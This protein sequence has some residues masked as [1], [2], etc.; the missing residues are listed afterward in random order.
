MLQNRMLSV[1]LPMGKAMFVISLATGLFLGQAH[2]VASSLV[3]SPLAPYP[4]NVG[5]GVGGPMVMLAASRDESLFSPIYTDYEDIDGGGIDFTFK[6]TF[7]YYGYFDPLKCYTY[8]STYTSSELGNNNISG[9]FEPAVDVANTTTHACPT[10][11]RYWSGNFLNWATMTRIDVVR[12]MLYGGFRRVDT[13]TDTTLEMA[14]MSQDAHSFVKYYSG[15]DVRNYTPF[16]TSELVVPGRPGYAG[17]TICNRSS[18]NSDPTASEPGAPLMRIAPGNY[19]LWATIPGSV[20]RWSGELSGFAFGQKTNAFY[21]KYGPAQGSSSSD[22]TA[23]QPGLP[24][25]NALVGV[26]P[27]LA[28]RVQVC[29]AGLLGSE[30]CQSYGAAANP[31][32]KPVGLLQEFGTT[33]NLNDPARAEF[34]L[35][36]GSYDANLRGGAL[37]KNVASLND[38]VDPA[39]GR[40]C[41][42]MPANGRPANCASSAGVIASFD[43][44]RLFDQGQYN[45]TAPV[46]SSGAPIGFPHPTQIRNGNFASWGNPVSEMVVQAISYFA[47]RDISNP[48]ETTRDVKVGLPTGVAVQ[49]PLDNTRIDPVAQVSRSQLYGQG[50]CRAANLLAI[51][52]GTTSFDTDEGTN[53]SEHVYGLF[54][55]FA[56]LN[57]RPN[58][59]LVFKTDRIGGLEGLNGTRRSVG[60]V[61][62]GFGADCSAKVIGAGG[63]VGGVYSR[64]LS[65]VTGVCPEAPA[66][67]GT[68]LGA[69]AAF[70][71]N[72][73]AIRELGG[74]GRSTEL[75][76]ATGGSIPESRLPPHAL[77]VRTYAASLAGGVAR[78]D[79]PIPGTNNKVYITPE[80]AWDHGNSA[81]L[82]TGAM[83]TF[84]AIYATPA[85][86][87]TN[88]SGA[89]VV[90]WNDTQF[91][92]D[93]DMDLV[94]FI[95]WELRPVAGGAFDLEVMTDVLNHNA[96]A[97][98]SHGFSVIG[99]DTAPNS[100]YRSDGRFITHGSNS[101]QGAGSRCAELA[102]NT[103][104]YLTRC[105][106]SDGGMRTSA[107][108]ASSRDGFNWPTSFNGQGVG[109]L[110]D[111]TRPL[112]TTVLTRFRVSNGVSAVTL[113]DPLWYLAKYGSFDTGETEFAA[114]SNAVPSPSNGSNPVNWDSENND[115]AACSSGAG[116]ADGEPDGY[117]LAR[118]PELLEARLRVL[119][120]RIVQSSNALPAVS[121]AQLIND[122]FKY[123]AE[124][125]AQ[126]F[127][128]TIKAFK[129]E[130]GEFNA[131]ESWDAGEA[132]TLASENNTR[133]I[134]TNQVNAAGVA[135]GMAFTVG[136]INA[137]AVGP[138][139]TTP[140]YK[141]TLG[142]GDTA[143]LRTRADRLV[144]YIRGSRADERTLFRPR[145]ATNLMG[146]IVSSSPWLQDSAAGARFFD[147]DFESTAPSYGAFVT[148]KAS[149]PPVLW[150]SSHDGMLHGF[151]AVSG[152]PI[153]SYL[154][155]MV[156]GQ[157]SA[158]VDVTNTRSTSL[159]DG[160]PYTGD[161]LVGTGAQQSWRT[162]LFSSMG[163]SG[164]GLFALDVTD[165][166]TLTEAN[167]AS[168]FRWV[169]TSQ[170]DEDL[171]YV[172]MDP[173]KHSVSGQATPLVRLNTGKFGL[174]V[175]NGYKSGTA[176]N[177]RAVLFILDAEGPGADGRWRD[178]SLNPQNYRKLLT[179]AT[180]TG[181]GLMGL[182]WVD[183]DSNGTADI[184]YATDL[185][186]Q[187][188]KFDI[189]ST[190]PTEWGA[191]LIGANEQAVPLFTARDAQGV[192]LPITTSPVVSFPNFG[193]AM[194]SFG[195]GRAIEAA[196][197]PRSQEF[198]RFFAVW[199]RGQY[200]GDQVNPA[201]EGQE[202]RALPGA[203]PD[204]L[205]TFIQ[206]LMV[207][208]PNSGVVYLA[209]VNEDGQVV[210]E[211][212]E[213]ASVPFDPS[214][215]DGWLLQFPAG[216]ESVISS[217]VNRQS[218][219]L[220][221]TVRPKESEQETCSN[222][223][224]ASVYALS[225]VS[226][227]PVPGLF[228]TQEIVLPDGTKIQAKVYGLDSNDQ[229]LINVTDRSIKNKC[230]NGKCE[231]DPSAECPPGKF[232]TRRIGA[233]TDAKMCAPSSQLRIQWREIPG[234]RT[235]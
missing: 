173:L 232:K 28:V 193:G 60:A 34:G 23:H 31:V 171:G 82:I 95:R 47:G 62:G 117:F 143:A 90:T 69:G 155:S 16:T 54:E 199:D 162:Y 46:N 225:P 169:F 49:D 35:I 235:Q 21:Q 192:A 172:L 195:T 151:N 92:G 204:G 7:R 99:A 81:G 118:R 77:R 141:I 233:G 102:T 188:W 78:I 11:A 228:P 88:A 45:N 29:R 231:P 133:R 208:D 194:I 76:T 107:S 24:A 91:G 41:H 174:L 211:G 67:K 8:N 191:A 20:C 101:F 56:G 219:L 94:G 93:Y 128:G 210:P 4:P 50:I 27:Q 43:A 147:A 66:I 203:G 196:D 57:G 224:L 72:T 148:A 178:A 185:K 142:G 159:L 97:R 146:A 98:G 205:G 106:F 44:I 154:P 65:A 40:F 230:V 198:N 200:V 214:K 5:Y 189:R 180:D 96:G 64:G 131:E 85:T 160:S 217:P 53:T 168:V 122:S 215:H 227:L 104:E 164:R 153:M 86:A 163:R 48:T 70:Y 126:T 103:T 129:L 119:L 59:S 2:T 226:G 134:I 22:P 13:S 183:L 149:R 55:R 181:N 144:A 58:E 19:T 156:V 33:R 197:F 132:L 161:L 136:A 138:S 75:T 100:N 209:R 63:V 83:L 201:P 186:G 84:R 139:S 108:N 207:R 36:T 52:S 112:K 1:W 124:F 229:R 73:R 68:Y 234:M 17:L 37:R 105:T 150:A 223:P 206:R 220:F 202:P 114:V 145:D 109:F 170:D 15:T 135:S 115:G 80:S 176:T 213:T 10:T 121:S 42:R 165:P 218:F 9:R 74:D 123:I 130:N 140:L 89:Y 25:A 30:R 158:A 3:A 61:N 38:E 216:G 152:A 125:N 137:S 110:D 157:I 222:A 79:V 166:N 71:A 12:K 39:T 175:P 127:T 120:E 18:R 190:D 116:C 113:R 221:T 187:L 111:A 184:V 51:S 6:P 212:S 167:A 26:G 177:Q 32:L 182:N 87:T 179:A 14:Q